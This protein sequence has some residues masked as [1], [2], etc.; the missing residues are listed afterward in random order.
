M[1]N[2]IWL[3]RKGMKFPSVASRQSIKYKKFRTFTGLCVT[4]EDILYLFIDLETSGLSPNFD[5]ILQV[6]AISN[7]SDDCFD[8]YLFPNHKISEGASDVTGLKMINGSL[9]LRGNAVHAVPSRE[10]FEWF[11]NYLLSLKK[12]HK[13]I[14]LV[15]HNIGFDL[16]FLHNKLW[17]NKLW[18]E[19]ISIIRGAID[20]LPIFRRYYPGKGSYSLLELEEYFSGERYQGQNSLEDAKILKSLSALLHGYFLEFTKDIKSF[21]ETQNIK[22][23][24]Y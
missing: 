11:M 6:S 9:C 20:T 2:V 24:K 15:G 16:R 17:K 13:T 5:D 10:A 21:L 22:K 19:F 14:V 3:F 23:K 1:R 12:I 8:I 7:K 18:T 4:G